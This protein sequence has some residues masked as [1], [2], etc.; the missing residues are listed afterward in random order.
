MKKIVSLIFVLLLV[1]SCAACAGE[2]QNDPNA[3]TQPSDADHVHSYVIEEV[4][5]DC[6]NDGQI[7]HRCVD[8]DETRIEVVPAYGHEITTRSCVEPANCSRCDQI[9]EDPIP[10]E[11]ESGICI[12][13]GDE[14]VAE[15]DAQEDDAQEDVTQPIEEIETEQ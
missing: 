3:T 8:C 15:N 2:A 12:F 6:V 5:A 14:E 9:V 10:H 11:Y 7:T 1:F 13:C 4:E